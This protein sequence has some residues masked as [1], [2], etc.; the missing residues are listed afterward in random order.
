VLFLDAG[1]AGGP[2]SLLSGRVL[3]GAGVGLSMFGGLL[4]FDLSR[5]VAP[6]RATVRF[7][8]VVQGAR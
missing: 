4:R 2:G 1:Q 5:A 6:D 8:I 3:A 7:D